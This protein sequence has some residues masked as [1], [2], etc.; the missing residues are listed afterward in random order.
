MAQLPRLVY[1]GHVPSITSLGGKKSPS[2]V[3]APAHWESGKPEPSVPWTLRK[4]MEEEGVYN[5]DNGDAYIVIRSLL[6]YIL[7]QTP[8][9]R[10]HLLI[11]S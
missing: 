9:E 5:L 2:T 11:L 7:L 10:R 1:T 6:V 3:V 4:C 8:C